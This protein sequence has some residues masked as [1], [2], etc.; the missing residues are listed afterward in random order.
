MAEIR[1]VTTLRC[2]RDEITASIKLSSAS[3]PM[4][5]HYEGTQVIEGTDF[6][7]INPKMIAPKL[8]N[9]KVA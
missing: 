1:T 7:T 2:K 5:K 6:R 9:K 8:T 3:Q 4:R